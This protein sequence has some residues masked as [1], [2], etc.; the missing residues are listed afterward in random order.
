MA[1]AI[2][3]TTACLTAPATFQDIVNQV[4]S[5]MYQFMLTN[6][7]EPSYVH[8]TNLMGPPPGGDVS[9]PAAGTRRARPTRPVTGC[10]TRCSNPLLAEYN[11][12]FNTTT[13]PYEQ[14][15]EGAIA[16]VLAE[17]AAWRHR[18]TTRRRR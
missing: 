2:R 7:P 16:T 4:V 6:N 3:S 12:D 15:T 10:C 18:P 5:Q 8:Q 11:A 14:L 13:T 1:S 9:T 17:Q